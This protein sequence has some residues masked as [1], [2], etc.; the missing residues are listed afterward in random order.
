MVEQLT[1][2]HDAAGT[3]AATQSAILELVCLVVQ[4]PGTASDLAQ[5]AGMYLYSL[6]HDTPAQHR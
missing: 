5:R 4:A 2:M 3:D 6:R 1:A